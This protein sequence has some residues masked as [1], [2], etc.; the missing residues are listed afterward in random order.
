MIE[1]T[2]AIIE[3]ENQILIA[4]RKQGKHL[5]GFWEFPGGK[6]E[7]GETPEYCLKRELLEELG[8]EVSVGEF[9]MENTHKYDEKTILL[10]SYMCELKTDE[11]E[12]NDHDKVEW[13]HLSQ[14]RD[15]KFAP[16]DIGI[17]NKLLN[18]NS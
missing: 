17:V 16:A 10:K 13:I 5:A 11:I 9:F 3:K 12:L 6:I 4:R 7:K 14:L 1:V 15:Y 18:E 2:A 8:I